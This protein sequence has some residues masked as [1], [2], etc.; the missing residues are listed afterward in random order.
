MYLT[1]DV[2]NI[3]SDGFFPLFYCT[4][5]MRSLHNQ[6]F[7]KRWRRSHAENINLMCVT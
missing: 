1:A 6:C 3:H 7:V 4:V 5:D 2:T